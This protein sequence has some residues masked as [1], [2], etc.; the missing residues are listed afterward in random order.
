MAAK[1][2]D[3]SGGELQR[4]VLCRALVKDP[5]LLMLDE[6]TANID[7]ETERA[8]L[9]QLRGRKGVTILVSHGLERIRDL[10]DH[11]VHLTNIQPD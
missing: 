8:I 1:G 9:T 3:L 10:V 4:L 2:R 5:F 6:G 11:E 7:E